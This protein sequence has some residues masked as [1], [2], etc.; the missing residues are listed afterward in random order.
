M[1]QLP[2]CLI[3]YAIY[4]NTPLFPY[5]SKGNYGMRHIFTFLAALVESAAKNPEYFPGTFINAINQI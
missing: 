2:L 1:M 3:L 4:L 5:K